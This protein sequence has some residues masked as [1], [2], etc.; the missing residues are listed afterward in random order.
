M[1]GNGRLV[2]AGHP[3]IDPCD[4]MVC[5]E[6]LKLIYSELPDDMVGLFE[7]LLGNNKIRRS[8]IGE[9]REKI[10]EILVETDI[11]V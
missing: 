10:A 7:D 9:L 8:S 6:M 4:K 1:S 11:D 2:A 3:S 5:D